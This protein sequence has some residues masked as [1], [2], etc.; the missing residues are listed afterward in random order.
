MEVTFDSDTQFE[1]SEALACPLDERDELA[2]LVERD[3]DLID[4]MA[5]WVGGAI[6]VAPGAPGVAEELRPSAEG[7]E[8]ASLELPEGGGGEGRAI[9]VEGWNED[10]GVDHVRAVPVIGYTYTTNWD[11]G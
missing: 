5:V 9:V 7:I 4:A 11:V 3:A 10:D 2:E 8:G 1:L 6:L